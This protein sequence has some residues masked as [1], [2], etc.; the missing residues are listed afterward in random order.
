MAVTANTI[1]LPV[2]A[3]IVEGRTFVPLRAISEAFGLSLAWNES[4]KSI[5]IT[6]NSTA[7]SVVAAADKPQVSTNAITMEQG[8]IYDLMITNTSSI[9][10][11]EIMVWN[12]NPEAISY[13]FLDGSDKSPAILRI[14]AN[15]TNKKAKAKLTIT[16]KGYNALSEDI[17]KNIVNITIKS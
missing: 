4:G 1:A 15:R 6:K 8:T 17:Y 13:E 12:D 7:S 9:P 5:S 11:R 16:Y 3:Q 14:T 10:R 2:P